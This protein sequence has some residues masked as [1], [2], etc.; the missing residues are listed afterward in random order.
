MSPDGR[1]LV[2][3]VAIRNASLWVHDAEGDRQTSL[4]ANG[5]KPKFT[6]DE[7]KL[8]YLFV[9]E[10]AIGFPSPRDPGDLRIADLASGRSEPVVP[11]VSVLDYD[12][13]ADGERVVMSAEDREASSGRGSASNP[14]RRVLF[15]R[16]NC[17]TAGSAPGRYPGGG[18]WSVP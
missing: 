12:I 10:A 18:T 7:K 6:P 11:G 4:E 13:S 17:P 2:T 16:R 15:Q 14:G 5:A 9:K 3:A 1:S 8:C